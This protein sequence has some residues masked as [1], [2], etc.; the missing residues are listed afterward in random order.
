MAN[1][2]Y[3]EYLRFLQNPR[4]GFTG[5][6]GPQG[7]TGPAGITGATGFTGPAGAAGNTGPTGASGTNG[8]NGLTGATGPTGTIITSDVAQFGYQGDGYFQFGPY[9]VGFGQ[10]AVLTTN[11]P[12]GSCIVQYPGGSYSE[13]PYVY[14][15]PIELNAGSGDLP[16][17]I[18]PMMLDPSTNAT[19]VLFRGK[20]IN[21]N[22]AQFN[23]V[24][25]VIG[26][27]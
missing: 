3:S 21:D 18:T 19:Q 17:V 15:S 5:G 13:K 1:I 4:C 23:F 9:R 22:P 6:T 7:P 14:A 27:T 11:S 20:D 16:Y 24:Y 12:A 25:L 10:T 26:P 2:P 8:T